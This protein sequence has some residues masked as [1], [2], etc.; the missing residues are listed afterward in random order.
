VPNEA[1]R[2]HKEIPDEVWAAF[3]ALVDLGFDRYV[4][5]TQPGAGARQRL[6]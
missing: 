5:R 3:E 2:R 1:S 6:P 4:I